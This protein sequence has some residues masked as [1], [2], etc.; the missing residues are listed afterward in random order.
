MDGHHLP[1]RA[2]PLYFLNRMLY[3]LQDCLDLGPIQENSKMNTFIQLIGVQ[4]KFK[5]F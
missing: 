4:G 1:N 5:I 2:W 3:L